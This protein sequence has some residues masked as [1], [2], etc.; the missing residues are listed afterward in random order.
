MILFAPKIHVPLPLRKT[1]VRQVS[2]LIWML[3]VA[4][5]IMVPL[6]GWAEEPLK[7]PY[8]IRFGTLEVNADRS[9]NYIFRWDGHE[10]VF[11]TSV[12]ALLS[13]G[14]M[15]FPGLPDL[16]EAGV[17]TASGKVFKYKGPPDV[18]FRSFM[19]KHPGEVITALVFEGYLD[20]DLELKLSGRTAVCR[21]D[22]PEGN[23][24][25]TTLWR[26]MPGQ[27]GNAPNGIAK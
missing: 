17:K 7:S 14:G 4:L 12:R 1:K 15:E 16:K 5:N 24:K 9:K 19:E 18:F 10:E 26:N 22:I 3:A 11:D 23:G 8:Q 27:E 20:Q 2:A 21:V 6:H 13:R 25:T